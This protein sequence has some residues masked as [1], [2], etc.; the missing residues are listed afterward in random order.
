MTAIKSLKNLAIPILIMAMITGFAA[1]YWSDQLVITGEIT[2]T[3]FHADVS[4]P[5]PLIWDDNEDVKD[6]GYIED[7][8]TDGSKK[9][10]VIIDNAYPCYECWIKVGVHIMWDSIPGNISEIIINAPPELD[11]WVEPFDPLPPECPTLYD[12]QLHECEELFMKVYC[13]VLE[14]EGVVEPEQDTTYEFTVT[15]VMIQYNAD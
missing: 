15:F 6:V 8:Y 3:E 9:I 11:V 1:A 13:H 2:T 5:T 4:L 10:V 14:I 12:V 7:A